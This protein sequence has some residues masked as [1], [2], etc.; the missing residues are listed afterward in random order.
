M[1][2]KAEIFP[3]NMDEVD[4]QFNEQPSATALASDTNAAYCV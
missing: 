4:S 3:Q 1:A 2:E